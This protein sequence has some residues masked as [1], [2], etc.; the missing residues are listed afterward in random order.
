MRG[1]KEIDL[2][3]FCMPCRV[4][5]LATKYLGIRIVLGTIFKSPFFVEESIECRQASWKK[6]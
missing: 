4:G 1:F 6:H 3:Y 2:L 5:D